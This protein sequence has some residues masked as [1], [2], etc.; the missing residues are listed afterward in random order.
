MLKIRRWPD[1]DGHSE[2]GDDLVTHCSVLLLKIG[3]ALLLVEGK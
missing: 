3:A 2:C 1:G